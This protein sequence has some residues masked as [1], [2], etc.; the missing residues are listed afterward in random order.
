MLND[1]YN[2]IKSKSKCLNFYNKLN[3]MKE[4]DY[5]EN[6]LIYN[7]STV[8]AGVKPSVTINLNTNGQNLYHH[9]KLFGA[10]F[11]EGI[12]LDYIELRECKNSI[13]IMIYDEHNL[14][15]AINKNDINEFLISKG[16][17]SKGSCID[18]LNTL[19]NNYIKHHCPHELGVFLGIPLSDVK[20]FMDCTNKK[21]IMCS[22]WKVFNNCK[23]TYKTFERY[24]K[25]K[26][27]T[28]NYI[29]EGNSSRESALRLKNLF[30]LPN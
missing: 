19:K 6:F 16:Y 4:K 11:I 17:P 25:V 26:E 20:D 9:W 18:Y 1:S 7:I 23:E 12:G 24:D 28:I 14:E 10:D 22:Y 5:I 27:Q 15:N 13:V 30:I 3:S 2:N 29:L 8:L 21:C